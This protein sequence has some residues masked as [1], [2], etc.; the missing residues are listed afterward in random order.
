MKALGT[1]LNSRTT[2]TTM[3]KKAAKPAG[4]R[5]ISALA[6]RRYRFRTRSKLRLN[7]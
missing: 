5:L 4:L 2:R 1:R 6:P 3:T 7:H